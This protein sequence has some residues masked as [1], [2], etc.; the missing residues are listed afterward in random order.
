M[1][2]C[3]EFEYCIQIKS[4]TYLKYITIEANS[5]NTILSL[6]RCGHCKALAPAYAEAAKMLKKSESPVP[7]AKVDCTV[8]KDVCNKHQVSGYPTLKWFKDGEAS[9]YD[10]PRDHDGLYLYNI[11][12]L[13]QNAFYFPD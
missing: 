10:G 2:S 5:N 1:V 8:E 6:F 11:T 12:C 3:Y 13:N 4:H 7:L 9:D